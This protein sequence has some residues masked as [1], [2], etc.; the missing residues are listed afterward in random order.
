MLKL[1]NFLVFANCQILKLPDLRDD[2]QRWR[3]QRHAGGRHVA[4]IA[5]PHEFKYWDYFERETS[6]SKN[7]KLSS[8]RAKNVEARLLA[9]LIWSA[10][11]ASQ[12]KQQSASPGRRQPASSSQLELSS[13]QKLAKIPACHDKYIQSFWSGF[14]DGMTKIPTLDQV[15]FAQSRTLHHI[16]GV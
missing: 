10:K 8:H 12:L 16:Q 7:S 11:L 5:I 13:W 4:S 1:I 3:E 2:R 15:I 9:H 14:R 6:L